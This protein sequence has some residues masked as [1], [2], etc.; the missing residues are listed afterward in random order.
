MNEL[1]KPVGVDVFSHPW[2][3]GVLWALELLAWNPQTF[4]R[5]VVILAR[6]SQTTIDD[7]WVNKPINSLSAIFRWWIPQ[8]AASLNDRIKALETLCGRFPDIGWR[9]CIQQ[10]EGRQQIASSSTRPRWRNDAARAGQPRTGREP[11]G[12]ARKAL[13]L[14]IRWPSHTSTTL[15][16]LI[17]RLGTM[18]DED[19]L[20][21]WNR[22]DAWLGTEENE[23]ARAT[24]REKI[25]LTFLTRWGFVRG[26]RA[27]DRGK[28][29]EMW[30]KLAPQDPVRRHAWLFASAWVEC[31]TDELDEEDVDLKERETRTHRLRT[32][33]MEKIWS[34][35]GLDGVVELLADCD[36]WT[37]GRYAADCAMGECAATAV[38][39]T[40]LSTNVDLGGKLDDFMRGFLSFVD[41]DLRATLISNLTEAVAVEQA[42]RLFKC[43][44]FCDRT[45]R[46]LDQQDRVVRNEYWRV[47]HPARPRLTESEITGLIDR[48]LEAERPRA[49]FCAV[50]FDWDKVETSRLKRLLMAVV[51]VS[52]EPA[53][54]CE[55]EPYSLSEA[56]NSLDGRPGVTVDE[57]A[58]LEFAFIQVLDRSEHGIPNI[59]RRV[60]ESPALFVRVLALFSKRDD[61]GQDPAEWQ[62]DDAERSEALG[63][64]AYR[65]LENL[66][67]L[68]GADAEG[69]IDPHVLSRWVI[70]ARR[71]CREHGRAGIGDALIGEFLSVAPFEEDGSWPCRPVCEVLETVTSR[72]VA[73]GFETG[74]YNA[75]GVH[76]RGLGEGGAQERGL[77]AKYRGYAERLAFDYPYV[78]NIFE[79]I[80]K[81]Y[82]HEAEREDSLVL[83]RK[84]L[85][86]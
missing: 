53:G 52:A 78:A 21:V 38:L 41:E 5:V 36:G 76:S 20:S 6:L 69:R 8:T 34:A 51:N 48:L 64:A 43:A 19:S 3:T 70:D 49:A 59:E 1:L 55:I 86:H 46:L 27:T 33:A 10:F 68:P 17:D 73:D 40:C 62:V 26:L 23:K 66:T 35:R 57:M 30:E 44:P 82:D 45:W 9:I 83:A 7:N 58:Q 32:E 11:F 42:V 16:D 14:A 50:R 67:R 77:S 74:V 71:L 18:A 22:I 2:R 25:R 54:D 28:A 75:R 12:F 29:R 81:G 80:A 79:R 39:R 24:L 47:V 31:S 84:R 60:T 4:P 56:L 15:G 37:L 63:R 85:E 61:G 65:L 13:D 72:D